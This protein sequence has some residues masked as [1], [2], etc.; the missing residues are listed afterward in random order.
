MMW[1]LILFHAVSFLSSCSANLRLSFICGCFNP[2]FLSSSFLSAHSSLARS[3]NQVAMT[4][5]ACLE[6][7]KRSLNKSLG[8]RLLSV[9]GDLQEQVSQA[10]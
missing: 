7:V 10:R 6:A 3:W 9:D 8:S 4:C 1:P 5:N 2:L